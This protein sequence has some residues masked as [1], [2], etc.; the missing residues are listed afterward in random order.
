MDSTSPTVLT[1]SMDAK[2]NNPLILNYITVGGQELC[3]SGLHFHTALDLRP[4][5]VLVSPSLIVLTVSV[6][7]GRK[8]TLNT[9]SLKPSEF[10]S[11][12][13]VEVAVLGSPSLIRLTVSLDVKQQQQQQ[14]QQQNADLQL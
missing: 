10:R 6:D 7:T 13:K 3:E 11:C 14:Q 4:L 9:N 1:V 2:K 12:V 5:A 8:S